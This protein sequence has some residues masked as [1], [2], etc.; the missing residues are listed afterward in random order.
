MNIANTSNSLDSLAVKYGNLAFF[1]GSDGFDSPQSWLVKDFFPTSSFGVIYGKSSSLK[2]FLAIDIAYHI[3]TGARWQGKLVSEGIVVYI[4]AEGQQ[5]ISR[6][7]KAVE[8]VHGNKAVNIKVH[9]KS[10]HFSEKSSRLE[11]IEALK[12]MECRENAK[13]KL[14]VVD[15]LSRCFTGDENQVSAMQDFVRGCDKVRNEIDASIMCIHHTGK[16]ESKGSRGSSALIGACDY[17]FQL[18]RNG[19]T[20]FSTFINNKQ[21]DAE[22]T[23]D[24]SFEFETID[25]GIVCEENEPIT[26][27]AIVNPAT[28]KN[29]TDGKNSPVLTV[30]R[31]VFGGRCTREELRMKC[32]PPQK[33]VKKN[34]LDTRYKRALDELRNEGLIVINQLGSRGHADDEITIIH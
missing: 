7:I 25:L 21:K 33:N 8:N 9:P 17:E 18:K 13:I 32:F 26:S 19:K 11:L 30:L 10:V 6:R 14:I 20:K 28:I 15:T 1:C 16:D 4:A 23:P 12:D 2:S 31:E 24:Y 3:A 27:L 5:G 29:Q 22:V 34:T